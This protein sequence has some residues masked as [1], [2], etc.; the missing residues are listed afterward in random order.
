[1]LDGIR[2]GVASFFDRN[3]LITLRD[4]HTPSVACRRPV[5]PARLHSWMHTK[6]EMPGPAPGLDA[7]RYFAC[8]VQDLYCRCYEV[9][10]IGRAA[11]IQGQHDGNGNHCHHRG[12]CGLLEAR[13]ARSRGTCQ[14]QLLHIVPSQGSAKVNPR[15]LVPK[16]RWASRMTVRLGISKCGS[17][18]IAQAQANQ[19]AAES[20]PAPTTKF[21]IRDNRNICGLEPVRFGIIGKFGEDYVR[22]FSE[23]RKGKREMMEVGLSES[24]LRALGE[25]LDR[26]RRAQRMSIS[27]FASKAGY[28]ERTGRKI[29]RG[30]KT[31][32]KTLLHFCEAV[33]VRDIHAQTDVTE[34][35]DQRHGSYNRKSFAGYIGH[36][37]AHRWSYRQ[38]GHIFRS[39][40]ELR[41]QE[42]GGLQFFE[43]QRYRDKS[44]KV[45][46]FS[47]SGE[48][49]ANEETGLIHFLTVDQGDNPSYNAHTHATWRDAKGGSAYAS[50]LV[51]LSKA[52]RVADVA[53]EACGGTN[54]RIRGKRDLRVWTGEYGLR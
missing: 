32:F 47:Q 31:R 2:R 53:A 17:P 29:L 4:G 34:F 21:P 36:Y 5:S 46:D 35:A 16:A 14:Q 42:Q 51:F 15:C 54:Q 38:P 28:D 37:D 39:V 30:E 25:R 19:S 10:D 48:V 40:F 13:K 24:E 26:I 12:A 44:G 20:V 3:N 22:R 27:D 52:C 11:C 43:N 49:Y 45:L 50:I 8:H 1:M 33:G 18:H 6:F 9:V 41:W 23:N 7:S